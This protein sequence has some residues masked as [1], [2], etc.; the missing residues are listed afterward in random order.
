MPNK[1][2]NQ[3]QIYRKL[4]CFCTCKTKQ[5]LKVY[6]LV[7]VFCLLSTFKQHYISMLC[8][9][10]N[11]DFN[12]IPA[13]ISFEPHVWDVVFDITS[14]VAFWVSSRIQ[15][16]T[17]LYDRYC[18][19]PILKALWI[20]KIYLFLYEKLLPLNYLI[21][22]SFVETVLFLLRLN[23]SMVATALDKMTMMNSV[24]AIRVR[25]DLFSAWTK[26]W[27]RFSQKTPTCEQLLK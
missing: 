6:P 16:S 11:S 4:I 10:R 5:Y 23:P 17:I 8:N 26:L 13:I 24:S 19:I 2:F 7:Y 22:T 3:D 9:I 12:W 27:Q 1:T 21:N 14:V 15:S 20:P 18:L 25:L